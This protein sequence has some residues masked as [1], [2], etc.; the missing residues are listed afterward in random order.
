[1]M[2]NLSA[3][4]PSVVS[5][6]LSPQEKEYLA[7]VVEEHQGFP[8]LK[9]LWSLMDEAWMELDCDERNIDDRVSRFYRHPV[10]LLNGLF[11]EQDDESQQNRRGFASWI[12]GLSPTRIADFGG[13][14]GGLARMIGAMNPESEVEV[15]EPHPH[16]GAIAL[17]NSTP[18][19]RYRDELTGKYDVILA[20]DVFE[21]VPDPLALAF[22]TGRCLQRGGTYLMANCFYPV[23]RCHLSVTYHFRYT[24]KLAMEAMGFQSKD[25]VVYGQSFTPGRALDLAAARIV[26]QR[27][28]HIYRRMRWLPGRVARPLV[29]FALK[30][31]SISK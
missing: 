19:V 4:I 22:E 16:P 30:R 18:N 6:C 15:I 2:D 20:T 1:M 21:H 7:V 13:G 12:H 29:E 25:A 10:W 27:S 17:A 11:I 26:E 31:G 14:F 9:E 23:I 5:H 8:R 3:L 24:W 28:Q